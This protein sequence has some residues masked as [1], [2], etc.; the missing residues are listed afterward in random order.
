M[1]NNY[2]K[3]KLIF[4]WIDRNIKRDNIELYEPFLVLKE[5]RGDCQGISNLFLAMCSSL[6]IP[7]RAAVG[8]IIREFKKGVF[9]YAFHQWTEIKL[10]GQWVFIDPTFNT[11][12]IG[13]NYIKFFDLEKQID[14]L[15]LIPYTEKLKINI[16][17]EEK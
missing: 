9:K 16:I 2:D 7:A 5:K 10:D 17:G 15:K 3:V 12:G 6:N 13:L 14:L 11:W 4:N 8:V 1:K